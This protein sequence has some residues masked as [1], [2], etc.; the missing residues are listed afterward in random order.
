MFQFPETPTDDTIIWRYIGL[1]KFLDLLLTNTIKFTLTTIASD[2]NEIKWILKNL[3]NSSEYKTHGDSAKRYIEKLRN[4]TYISCWTMKENE[5]RALWSTYLD[6][7]KQG[8]AI[9]ST[10]GQL[11][12]SITC[13]DFSLN[14][15]IVDYR[16]NFNFEEL[17][18]GDII[19]NTKNKAYI[20]ES[21][22]RFSV[23][24]PDSNI[25]N[26][27][28]LE[29]YIKIEERKLSKRSD[30]KKI[31]TFDINLDLLTAN[32]MIPP[33][34]SDWQKNN[35]VQLIKDYKPELLDRI[36]DSTINE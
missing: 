31:I 4:T 29:D 20:E 2:K 18:S 14:C 22:V 26:H 23:Y 7:N 16:N 24:L 1:D 13:D 25:P 35:L 6:N 21:E 8:V 30:D 9:K 11:T 3:E 28:N 17:Q 15:K 10:V 36:I 19:I 27:P 33:Y 12:N 5:S 32:I 34:C